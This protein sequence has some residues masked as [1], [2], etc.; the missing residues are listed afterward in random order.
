M[1]KITGCIDVRALG[2]Y[3]F[4]FY[5]PDDTTDEEIKTKV[6]DKCDYFIYYDVE[7]GYKK[8]TEMVT[9]YVKEGDF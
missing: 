8:V 9:K 3:D 6:E 4:E 7:N 1:K 5:V 2:R